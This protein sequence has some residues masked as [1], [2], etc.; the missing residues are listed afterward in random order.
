MIDPVE[1]STPDWLPAA[2]LEVANLVAEMAPDMRA[3]TEAV[4]TRLVVDERMKG[5]WQ[6]LGKHKR[7]GAPAPEQFYEAAPPAAVRSWTAMAEAWRARAAAYRALGDEA[8]AA[9]Y[10]LYAA[11][12]GG[13]GRAPPPAPPNEDG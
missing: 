13:R 9:Q 1:I 4:L 7:E 8:T 10:E 11:A 6:D 3:D 12:S 2:V 5:V